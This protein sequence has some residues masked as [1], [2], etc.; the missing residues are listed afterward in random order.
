M[1]KVAFLYS[2]FPRKTETFVRRELRG[3]AKLGFYPDLYSLWGGK[4]TWEGRG[5]RLFPK[6]KLFALFYWIPY[7]A[8]RKPLEFRRTL[9]N[10]WGISCPN[11]QNF[12]ETFLGLGFALVEARNFERNGYQ[13]IHGVWAT[14]PA[15]AA[16]AVSRLTGIPFSMG[17]HAYDL[18]RKGGDWL[19]ATKFKHASFVRTSSKSSARRLQMLGVE[20]DR[21]K[22]IRRGLDHRTERKSFEVGKSGEP[23]N[24]VSVGRLV[25]KKGYFH[26]L[27]MA[28]LLRERGIAFNWS[29]VGSGRLLKS[30]RAE[31][32][33]KNLSENMV[34]LGA[35]S[36]EEVREIFLDAD[37]M[38]FTGIIDE[39]GDR[40]GIPN[41]IPEAMEAG[42]LLLGSIYAGAS[43]AF[44]DGVS[45]FSLDPRDWEKW[46]DILDDFVHQPDQYISIRKKGIL[47]AR[48]NFDILKTARGLLSAIKK[49][50]NTNEDE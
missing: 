3:L 30:L 49:A 18:F 20:Q 12:N 19:L 5:V 46:V 42:C 40:D 16:F 17:A 8:M 32:S 48:E 26:Q 22:F 21:V 2:T 13:L 45:G 1:A 15:T 29:I 35:R 37:A 34:L 14:M 31:I 9:S 41:V 43:E 10:L 6:R 39:K 27:E 11:L 47:H 38:V 33:R 4:K 25:P 7:W 44:V 50:M 36:E 28:S 23:L 24:V